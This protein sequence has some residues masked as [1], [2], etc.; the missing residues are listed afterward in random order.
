MKFEFVDEKKRY[1]AKIKVVGA[2]GAGGNAIN[3]MMNSS[4]KGVDFIVA[5]TDSQD[6]DRSE[7]SYK[8]QLGP[9]VTMGLGA[10]ADPEIGEKSAEESVNDIRE[11]VAGSD[12]V[13][14]AAGMGGGTG[15][16]ASPVI[17]RAARESGALTL[18]LIHI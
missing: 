4:L 2:G 16:G 1:D 13:F 5:N 9:T 3:N 17:A 11:C 15:T 7:C 8:I 12:M 18:S 10:G 14:I 6:L